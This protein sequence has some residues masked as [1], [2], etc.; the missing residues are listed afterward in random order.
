VGLGDLPFLILE[1]VSPGAV[2]DTRDTRREGGRVPA[3][4][5]ALSGGLDTDEA[6]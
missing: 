1:K 6:D 3:G 2:Q 5:H 4:L